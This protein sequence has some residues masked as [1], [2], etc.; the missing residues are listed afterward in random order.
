MEGAG[1]DGRVRVF[2]RVRPRGAGED[3]CLPP[4]AEAVEAARAIR[5]SGDGDA[6]ERVLAGRPLDGVAAPGSVREFCFDGV[7]AGDAGQQEVFAQ[8]GL[9]VLQDFLR[10]INGTIFAYGQTG[11]GK[12]HSLLHQGPPSECAGLLP[13]LVASLFLHVSRDA[14]SAYAVEVAAV[15]VYNEQVDD[16]LHPGLQDGAGQGLAVHNGGAVP[17][18]TWLACQQP[19]EMLEAF[20]RARSGLVYAETRM[21]K[22]SSRSHAVFQ[23]RATRRA[24]EGGAAV[25][26]GGERARRIECTRSRLCV[27][28]LAGSERAAAINKS[29]LALGNVVSALAARI[30]EGRTA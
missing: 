7:F 4:A 25:E 3:P 28:D 2:A 24:R 14:E 1:A 30:G 10:G 15:Q 18:L 9:P 23:I 21:N 22:A 8:V 19:C 16:L 26:E 11:S 13:R 12:T 17:G 20:S 5:V 27:V 29:L 6:L